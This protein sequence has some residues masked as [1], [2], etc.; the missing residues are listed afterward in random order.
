MARDAALV[1]AAGSVFV[2][3]GKLLDRAFGWRRSREDFATTLRNE[4]HAET[5]ALKAE[6]GSLR[7]EVNEWREKYLSEKELNGQLRND[8]A[9]LLQDHEELRH[10]FDALT[11][12]LEESGVTP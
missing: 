2:F 6:I 5:A 3:L 4:L 9:R 12:R 7:R 8:Y 10:E 1:A 11:Q